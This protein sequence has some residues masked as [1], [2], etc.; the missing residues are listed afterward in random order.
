MDDRRDLAFGKIEEVMPEVERLLAG[1]STSKGWTLGQILHHLA[2]A[3]RLC[4]VAGPRDPGTASDPVLERTFKVRRR[5]FFRSGRF[6]EG[7]EVPHPALVPPPEADERV[8]A[9]SLRLGLERLGATEGPFAVHPVLGTMSKQEW[10]DF[11]RIH[12]AHHLAF[13]KVARS[14]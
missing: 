9:E 5:L 3:V 13:A 10:V 4:L 14:V 2:T 8:E 11:H 1:H 12:C 6:P 7:L